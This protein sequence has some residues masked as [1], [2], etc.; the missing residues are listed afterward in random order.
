VQLLGG[1]RRKSFRQVETHLPA[2]DRAGTGA[3][4]V[5]LGVALVENMAHQVEVLLHEYRLAG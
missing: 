4:T 3:G 1:D 5:G 2:K